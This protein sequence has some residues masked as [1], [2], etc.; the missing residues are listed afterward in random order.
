[1]KGR[2]GILRCPK[3]A[4]LARGLYS[5]FDPWAEHRA[6]MRAIADIEPTGRTGAPKGRF[7]YRRVEVRHSCGHVWLTTHPSAQRRRAETH[8][9]DM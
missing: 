2:P 7:H 1:M 8:P 6:M 9:K 4:K 3:C 5:R